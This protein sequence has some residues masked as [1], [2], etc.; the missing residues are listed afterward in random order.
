MHHRCEWIH[1]VEL[2]VVLFLTLLIVI[3]YVIVD[4]VDKASF[5][6]FLE[7]YSAQIQKNPC[8]YV[9]MRYRYIS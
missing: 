5:P 9:L 7:N 8:D 6:P 1:H 3:N 4:Y 2:E